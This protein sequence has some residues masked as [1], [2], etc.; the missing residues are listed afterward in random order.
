MNAAGIRIMGVFDRLDNLLRAVEQLEGLGI[1]VENVYSPA[2]NEQIEE[3]LEAGR[4]GIRWF[5]LAGGLFGLMMAYFIAI[6]SASAWELDIWG[7]PF[8]AWVPFTLVAYEWTIV[9]AVATLF[10]GV[11]ILARQKH[12]QTPPLYDPRFTVDR[13]GIVVG[14]LVSERERVVQILKETRAEKIDESGF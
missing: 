5:P 3:K 6:Y 1:P 13:F 8:V 7:K 2:P 10:F 9:T 12:L 14:C 11:I 4:S